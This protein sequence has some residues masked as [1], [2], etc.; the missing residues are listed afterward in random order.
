MK[1]AI[2]FLLLLSLQQ[3][4]S[5]RIVLLG[6]TQPVVMGDV[7]REEL[8]STFQ[9]A[10]TVAEMAES[11]GNQATYRRYEE[12]S[13]SWTVKITEGK[14]VADEIAEK[15]GF[16]NAG[17]ASFYPAR[18]LFLYRTIFYMCKVFQCML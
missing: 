6:G 1:I 16:I 2:P 7:C 14:D 3:V 11:I 5:S 15:Y 12:Y 10:S 4:L 13:I 18:Y 17:Q 9:A 8:T